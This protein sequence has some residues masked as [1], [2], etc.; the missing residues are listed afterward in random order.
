MFSWSTRKQACPYLGTADD[1]ES[2][3]AYPSAMNRCYRL[4]EGHA[5]SLS[6]Q[7]EFCLIE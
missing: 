4:D 2:F 1:P 3:I 7:A 6:H 5:V